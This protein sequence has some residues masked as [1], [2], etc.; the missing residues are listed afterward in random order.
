VQTLAGRGGEGLVAKL[1]RGFGLDDLDLSTAEDGTAS[2]TAGKYISRNTY[3]EVEVDQEGRS[4]I[5]LNLD[6][7][8]NLTLRGQVDSAGD[9]GIGIFLEKDY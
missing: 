7:T 9:T 1:R 5:S 3:T 6:V 8:E 4:T 2:L